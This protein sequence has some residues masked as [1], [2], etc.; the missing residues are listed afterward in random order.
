MFVLLHR[1]YLSPYTQNVCHPTHRIDNVDK[2]DKVNM[3][4]IGNMLDMVDMME[5]V[6]KESLPVGWNLLGGQAL[7]FEHSILIKL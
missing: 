2:M 1:G 7:N 5:S 6:E 4:D 3:V